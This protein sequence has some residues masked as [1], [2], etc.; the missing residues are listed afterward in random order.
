MRARFTID[1]IASAALEI[2]DTSGPAALSMRGLATALGTGPMTMYNYVA[3]KEGL[4]E[5]V[6]AAVVADVEVPEPSDD[7]RQDVHAVATAMWRGVRA[8]PAAVPLVLTRRMT[9]ATG[10]AIADAL[11]GALHR[12]G[13][14]DRDRLSAFHAVLALV[15][16]AAQA[17]LAGPLMR[18]ADGAAHAAARIGAVA[19]DDHPHITALSAV[20]VTT[21]VEDDFDGGLRMLID[22]IAAR[23]RRRR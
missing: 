13:L 20:A 11:V 17:E 5:L 1:E 19:G 8:H 21:S 4:E 12:A 16:G 3:D 18:D 14:S 23:A 10:F 7:W 22:G 15:T 9:S 6:V 2:V